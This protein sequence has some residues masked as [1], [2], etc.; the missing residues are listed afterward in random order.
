[1]LMRNHGVAVVGASIEESTILTILLENACEIQL[2]ADA[3]GAAG[4]EFDQP[5]IERLHDTITK[6]EQYTIN[7]E[8][9]R[10]RAL[11]QKS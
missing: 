3:S 9:L 10:R 5:C 8:Y 4:A 7:F 11:R 1:V 6:T 2:L